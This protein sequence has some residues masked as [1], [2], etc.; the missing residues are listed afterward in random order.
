[1]VFNENM[2]IV[3]SNNND[4]VFTGK[5]ACINCRNFALCDSTNDCKLYKYLQERI[6][7]T[8]LNG[9]DLITIKTTDY[10]N[11]FII[12]RRAIRLRERKR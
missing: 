4:T 5:L 6:P 12:V 7:D 10:N 1:M 8:S 3:I 11:A 9:Q 2:K